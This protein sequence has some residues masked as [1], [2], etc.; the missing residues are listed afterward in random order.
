MALSGCGLRGRMLAVK[1]AQEVF[2]LAKPSFWSVMKTL[3]G[4]FHCYSN[5]DHDRVLARDASH[6]GQSP[7]RSFPEAAGVEP[8]FLLPLGL[9]RYIKMFP[10]EN[11][12]LFT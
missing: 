4:K 7:H 6:P 12:H 2:S 8:P 10:A 11:V 3:N 1:P 5:N 9:K